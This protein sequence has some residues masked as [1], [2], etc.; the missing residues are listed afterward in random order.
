MPVAY[1]YTKVPTY[2]SQE[3]IEKLLAKHGVDAFRWTSLAG[4][5]G[6]EFRRKVNDQ[7]VGFCV[8][9]DYEE[10]EK[11]QFLRALFFWIKATLEAVEFGIVSFERAFMPA[12]ITGEGRTLGD[13]VLQRLAQGGLGR[14]VPLLPEGRN[15]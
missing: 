11:G 4:Q 10:R 3:Q 13:D 7:S 6:L 8:K 15:D 9:L 12:L 2:R 1:K 5:L 14:D